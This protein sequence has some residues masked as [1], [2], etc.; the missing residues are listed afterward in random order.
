MIRMHHPDLDGSDVLAV[1]E[2]QALHYEDLGWERTP[3]P[4]DDA[5]TEVYEDNVVGTTSS[6]GD[7]L[8][9]VEAATDPDPLAVVPEGT[10]DDV[11]AWVDVNGRSGWGARA[12][13]ALQAEEASAHP[14]KTI[15]EPLTAALTPDED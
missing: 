4:D 8:V 12:R 14:R 15:T 9:I 11:L 1:S 7:K 5:P 10:V 2:D 3:D 6:L 13:L